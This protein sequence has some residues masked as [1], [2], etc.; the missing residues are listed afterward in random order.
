M[1]ASILEIFTE[2]QEDRKKWVFKNKGN[3]LSLTHSI[4]Q[5]SIDLGVPKTSSFLCSW[6]EESVSLHLL[7]SLLNWEL[8]DPLLHYGFCVIFKGR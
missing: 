7:L 5:S 8:I 2:Y 4:C 3:F 1:A 6:T